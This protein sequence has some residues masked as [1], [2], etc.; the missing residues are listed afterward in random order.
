[1]T[2]QIR[3]PILL[4]LIDSAHLHALQILASHICHNLLGVRLVV[5]H[6]E[7]LSLWLTLEIIVLKL[8]QLHQILLLLLLQ[9]HLLDNLL[10][11]LKHL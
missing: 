1:M 10:L 7:L 3:W 6:S 8:L 5:L 9:L 2:L 4:V 11:L